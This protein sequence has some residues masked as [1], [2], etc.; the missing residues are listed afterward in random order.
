M[1]YEQPHEFETYWTRKS[2]K[3]VPYHFY[4]VDKV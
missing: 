3:T 4:G 2:D 1:A